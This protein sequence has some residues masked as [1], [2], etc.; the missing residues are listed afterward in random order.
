MSSKLYEKTN[1]KIKNI[2][3]QTNTTVILN[4]STVK[5]NEKLPGVTSLLDIQGHINDFTF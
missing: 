3:L 2:N 4:H 5:Y 1:R